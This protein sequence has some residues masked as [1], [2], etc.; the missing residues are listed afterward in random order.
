MYAH[1][2][3]RPAAQLKEV[4]LERDGAQGRAERA[5][6]TLVALETECSELR[7]G[8]GNGE[9]VFQGVMLESGL[10]FCRTRRCG[11]ACNFGA[12]KSVEPHTD[13][14]EWTTAWSVFK[15]PFSSQRKCLR[16]V[17]MQYLLMDGRVSAAEQQVRL[18]QLADEC[19]LLVAEKE[20]LT[21]DVFGL[22]SEAE[23]ANQQ[24]QV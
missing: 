24:L 16:L 2:R 22:S 3:E 10:G 20:A 13:G 5:E 7:Y 18:D 15:A 14:A 9:G 19:R 6:S 11:S 17:N 12:P 21:N 8:F 1:R 4:E 23:S